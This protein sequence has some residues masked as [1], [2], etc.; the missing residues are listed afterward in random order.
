MCKTVLIFKIEILEIQNKSVSRFSEALVHS[1]SVKKM[2]LKLLQNTQENMA[3][4]KKTKVKLELLTD[5]FHAVNG[6]IKELEGLK[7]IQEL[8]CINRYAKANNKN[9][10]DNNKNKESSYLKYWDVNHLY[11]WAMSQKL[12]VDGFESAEDTSQFNED[13]LK[14]S[15]EENDKGYFR[16]VSSIQLGGIKTFWD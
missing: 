15:N 10:N 14:I 11:G 5:N 7:E 12:P 1:L 2:F 3:T 6:W 8:D 9:M 13:F 4:L 16:E